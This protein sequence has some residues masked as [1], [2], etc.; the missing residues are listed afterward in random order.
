MENFPLTLVLLVPLVDPHGG[1]LEERLTALI[2]TRY[3]AGYEL[4]SLVEV[5][6]QLIL[7]FRLTPDAVV[8]IKVQ[9]TT[10]S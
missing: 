6:G 5:S 2:D 10:A 3:A 4:V 9:G 8:P 7:I 1:G